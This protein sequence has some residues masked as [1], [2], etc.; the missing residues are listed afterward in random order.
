VAKQVHA[1]LELVVPDDWND[2]SITAY[3]GPVGPG[4]RVAP[5]IVVTRDVLGQNETLPAYTD[6]QLVQIAQKLAGFKLI[7]RDEVVL[8]GFPAM[9]M[10]FSWVSDNGELEQHQLFVATSKRTIMS[11]VAT[12]SKRDFQ[13]VKPL[14][15]SIY[16]SVRFPGAPAPI[17]NPP[18]RR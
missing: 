5:N 13:R 15:A 11:F 2:R 14:F 16:A 3:A 8:S 7:S 9:E 4:E 6:R 17:A 1:D 10:R 18:G 12:A